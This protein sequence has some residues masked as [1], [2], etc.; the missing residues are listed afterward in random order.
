[1][2]PVLLDYPYC[3]KLDGKKLFCNKVDPITG[4]RCDGE[5]DYDEGFNHLVCT[6]CGKIYLAS[7]LRDN[8]SDNKIVIKGGTEM[9][10]V[11]KQGDKVI[12][13]S[14]P[15][16]ETIVR[17]R[18][19]PKTKGLVVKTNAPAHIETSLNDKKHD[20]KLEDNKVIKEEVKPIIDNS[21]SS[22]NNNIEIKAESASKNIDDTDSDKEASVEPTE[23]EA[24]VN[25]I[26][27][28]A[29]TK[30]NDEDNLNTDEDEELNTKHTRPRDSSGKFISTG[31]KKPKQKK[32][33]TGSTFIPSK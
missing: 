11:L 30:S 25:N 2:G 13:T 4:M 9:K 12:S 21:N 5:I 29:D 27:T 20:A 14:M 7:D 6:K 8:K 32:N 17:P 26:D 16:E 22:T 19:I 3:Y 18:I 15:T 33:K 24:E 31:A 10:I 23:V 1:M 28:E